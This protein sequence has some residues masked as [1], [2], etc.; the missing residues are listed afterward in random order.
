MLQIAFKTDL[1]CS[2]LCL[3]SYLSICFDMVRN[4]QQFE[5]SNTILVKLHLKVCRELY[6]L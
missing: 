3:T 4:W 2:L 6:S 5:M 1:C